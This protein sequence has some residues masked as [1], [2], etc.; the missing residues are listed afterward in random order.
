MHLL[1]RIVID[2][3]VILR[4]RGIHRL[5][6]TELVQ[7]RSIRRIQSTAP[8]VLRIAIVIRHALA[9]EVVVRAHH[10]P[11][12]LLRSTRILAVLIRRPLVAMQITRRAGKCRRRS[13]NTQASQPNTRPQQLSLQEN[14]LTRSCAITTNLP[15]RATIGGSPLRRYPVFD[16]R[17]SAL[18]VLFSAFLATCLSAAAQ[19][20]ARTPVCAGT[21]ADQVQVVETMRTMYA[22]AATDDLAK[23]HTVAAPD[24]YAFDGGTRYDGDALMNTLKALHASGKVYVWSVTQPHVESDCH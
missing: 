20:A 17:K 15:L 7:I 2:L 11:R 10:T 14:L 18:A 22:A 5:M 19:S 8:A 9:A 12:N 3:V 1:E 4:V 24:F 13:Q 21:P 23:F 16:A 6:H